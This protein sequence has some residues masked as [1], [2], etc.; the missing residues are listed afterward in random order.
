MSWLCSK[1]LFFILFSKNK[2]L[3]F[4]RSNDN[5]LVAPGYYIG[6]GEALDNSPNLGTFGLWMIDAASLSLERAGHHVDEVS[7]AVALPCQLPL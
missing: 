7:L 1:E 4:I 6:R 2:L 3:R 5:N